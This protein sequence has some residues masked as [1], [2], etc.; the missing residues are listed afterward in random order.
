MYSI[1]DIMYNI[2]GVSQIR[3]NHAGAPWFMPVAIET[4][5]R[6]EKP[7]G[8]TSASIGNSCELLQLPREKGENREGG[9]GRYTYWAIEPFTI[10]EPE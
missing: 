5:S 6:N 7:S 2:N 1:I 10:P 4:G 3:E 8:T 9:R